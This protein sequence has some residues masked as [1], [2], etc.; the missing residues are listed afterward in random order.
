MKSVARF[1]KCY[2]K[3]VKEFIMS[4]PTNCD[5]KK[6]KEYRKVYAR[7]RCLEFSP[8]VTNMFMGRSDDEQ[9]EVE[10]I[11]NTIY[12]E[13]TA[14]KVSQWPRKGKLSVSKL[15]VKYI[16]LHRIGAANWVLTNHTST[17]ATCFGKFIYVVGIKTKFYFGSYVFEQTLRHASTFAMKMPIAF[18]SLICGIILSQH[19]RIL[20][21]SD[22]AIKKESPLSLYY[23]LFAGTHVPNIVMTSGKETSSLTSKD[24]IIAELKDT[25]KALDETIKTCIEKK[26]RLEE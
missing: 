7:G 20:I 12:K 22:A 1:G 18:P 24:G 16:V 10:V 17:I 13:I 2:E 23:R 11:D 14:K 6:S 5:N 4:I 8:E 26:I 9:A 19:P 25:C 21:T 3:L 15:S